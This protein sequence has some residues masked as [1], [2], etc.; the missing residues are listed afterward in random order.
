MTPRDIDGILLLDKPLGVSSAGAVA[1]A[2]YLFGARK[3]GHMGSLD[4]LA[5]GLLPICFGEATKFG[6]QM[7]DA[8]KTYRVVARLGQRT[9]SADLESHVIETRPLPG[10][11][12]AEIGAALAEF[13]RDY[14]QIP[15]MH[16]ALKQDGKPLYAYARAGIDRARDARAIVIHALTLL[17]WTPPDLQFDVR[18][19]T[20]YDRP[21]HR[22]APPGR[23]PVRRRGTARL[24]R[25]RGPESGAASGGVAA[26][27]CRARG[28]AAP[29]PAARRGYGGAAWTVGGFAG[30]PARKRAD[31]CRGTRF[32]GIGRG[33][34]G[35]PARPI[36]VDF[37]GRESC[38]RT[39]VS[40]RTMR[41]FVK[42]LSY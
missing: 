12:A 29:R 11:S 3:A 13:P 28:L 18:R 8:D 32:S 19:T 38:L 37:R 7:L 40:A 9:A 21:S 42:G 30:L 24:W 34:G 15:P 5:S 2:K 17:D 39:R 36:A 27:R 26:G 4:P 16:S 10:F 33:P 14:A 1:R 20:R 31:L 23:R 35:R 41:A 6:A 25:A 22:P